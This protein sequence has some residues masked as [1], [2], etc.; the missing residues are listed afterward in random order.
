M[1]FRPTINGP[2]PAMKSES[3]EQK[4]ATADASCVF[5]VFSYSSIQ[6]RTPLAV[7]CVVAGPGAVHALNEPS[8]HAIAVRNPA[9]PNLIGE[10]VIVRFSPSGAAFEVRTSMRLGGLPFQ[11][12]VGRLAVIDWVAR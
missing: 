12:F 11:G 3:L 6:A 5:Q 7:S 1:A 4:D 10:A 8:E 9:R 2:L